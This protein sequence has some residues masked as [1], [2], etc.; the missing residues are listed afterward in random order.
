MRGLK[1]RANGLRTAGLRHVAR[2]FEEHLAEAQRR[3]EL[4]FPKMSTMTNVSELIGALAQHLEYLGYT[5]TAPDEHGWMY[6]SHPNRY[7]ISFRE[8]A[9]GVLLHG[10]LGLGERLGDKRDA[11]LEFLNTANEHATL[12]RFWLTETSD[13]E[14]VVRVR[15]LLPGRYDRSVFGELLDLW[16]SDHAL[17]QNAPAID[18]PEDSEGNA[19]QRSAVH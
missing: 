14:A 3:L 17:M 16:H 11:W 8:V 6:A 10:M 1:H 15:A 12:C 2:E 7:T 19:R 5:S 18:A 13:G 4:A 9:C